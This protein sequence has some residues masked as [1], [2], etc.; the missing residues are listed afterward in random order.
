MTDTS[1][2]TPATGLTRREL[3]G[4]SLLLGAGLAVSGPVLSACGSSASSSGSVEIGTLYPQGSPYYSAYQRVASQV[5]KDHKGTSIK[6][7]FANTEARPKL[8]LR[9]KH[10][11]P[12][13]LDYVFNSADR[14]SLHYV[15]DGD[16]LDL[17]S[18]MNST[19]WGDGHTWASAILPAFRHFAQY[20]GK[21]YMAPESAVVMGLF[22]NGKL[23]DQMGLT[24]PS[25]WDDL[26][27][28]AK[29]IRAK[30]VSPI[31][32]TGTFAPYMGLWWDHLLLREIGP[33]AVMNVAWGKGKLSDQPGALD[34]AEKLAA[35]VSDN[36]FLDGFSGIDFT[37]AQASFFQSKAA[38]ILMGS[39]LQSEMKDSIPSG[40]DLRVAPFPTVP[41]GQGDQQG[42]FGTM[43]GESVA[44]KSKSPDVA[45]DYLRVT[46]SKAE[47][48]KRVQDLGVVSPYVG[49][50]SPPGVK[51]MD[52][53]L[54]QASSGTVTYYYY[55][56]SQEPKH[57]DAWYGPVNKLFL[58]KLSPQELISSIDSNLSGLNG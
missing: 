12:P 3:L 45:V 22:Y 41:G 19:Q 25:T 53:L 11:N 34:A 56:I 30:G 5:E 51:G 39:W 6:F 50:P 24:P 57:S 48:E 7:T 29:A 21:Y 18:Q 44:K 23:F 20:Q 52:T 58:G 54:A 40:F 36:A 15:T 17:T 49:M 38:M 16:L 47:Q 42:M 27:S 26:V 28:T 13:D 43:L 31:A 46:D 14:T 9:W 37:A 32:V 35:L 10:G 55:G 2:R 4:R 8:I 33:D 1:E